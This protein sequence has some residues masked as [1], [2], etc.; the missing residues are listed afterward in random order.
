MARK[1]KQQA[2][3]T[4]NQIIEA[5]ITLFSQQGGTTP[6][7]SDIA[8]TAGVTRGAIYWHFKN[9]TDLLNHIWIQS[10][11]DLAAAEH[12]YQIKYPDDPLSFMRAMLLYAIDS[13]VTHPRKRA[14]ME[15]IFHKCEFVGKI[16]AL[17][18]MQ[19]TL[20]LGYY[21][22]IESILQNCIRQGQLPAEL[23]TRRAAIAVRGYVTGIIENW[24]FMPTSF[25]IV[26]DAPV[27]IDALIDTLH[28]SLALR[29]TRE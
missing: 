17:Q 27:L 1:T 5:A 26:A 28:T 25:D 22:K 11:S 10:G 3:E 12:E 24:L 6:S 23:H 15:I 20:Y 29:H 14:L 16:V 21:E 18:L 7:L 13:A 19:Q 8:K 9:K 4:R 2:L